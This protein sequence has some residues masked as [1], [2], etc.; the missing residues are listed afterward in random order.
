M[1]LNLSMLQHLVY[2]FLVDFPITI[3]CIVVLG[4][5]SIL[6]YSILFYSILFYCR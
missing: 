2:A 3:Q 4:F 5:H 1:H 6:F